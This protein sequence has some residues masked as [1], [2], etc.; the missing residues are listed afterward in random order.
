MPDQSHTLPT[1]WPGTCAVA[2]M[3]LGDETAE[4]HT[5]LHVAM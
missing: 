1:S 3:N 5:T 4:L 2:R